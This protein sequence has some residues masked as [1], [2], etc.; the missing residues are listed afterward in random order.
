MITKDMINEINRLSKISKER[1]LTK[2]EKAQQEKLRKEYI[3]S[4]RKNFKKQLDNIEIV[5]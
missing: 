5:D 2:D 4:F 1:P 3:V